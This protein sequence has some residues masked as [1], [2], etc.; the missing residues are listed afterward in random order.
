LNA[1]IA[2]EHVLD[3]YTGR[4]D[5]IAE[6][7]AYVTLRDRSGRGSFAELDAEDLAASGIGDRDRFVCTIK[8]RGTETVLVLEKTP[9]PP[10]TTEDLERIEKI[11]DDALPDSVLNPTER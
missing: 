1:G 4:V 6:G 10:E 8:R 11:L 2:E 3:S 9:R 7:I 5:K